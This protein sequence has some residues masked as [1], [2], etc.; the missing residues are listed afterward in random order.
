MSPSKALFSSQISGVREA[1]AGEELR[2][3]RNALAAVAQR[4]GLQLGDAPVGKRAA[5]ARQA[6]QIVVV[7]HHRFAV[8]AELDVAFDREAAGDRRFGGA[9]RVFRQ[10]LG[11]V[12]ETAMGDRPRRQPG[13]RAHGAI[14]NSASTSAIDPSGRKATPTVVRAWRPRSPNAAAIRSEAPFIACGSAS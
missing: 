3:G 12:V 5:R 14:S 1:D 6:A 9:D 4:E 2:Q 13:R 10:A 8:A 7:E 11:R